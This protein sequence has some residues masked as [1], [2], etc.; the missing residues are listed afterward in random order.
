LQ[1]DVDAGD[2]RVRSAARSITIDAEFPSHALPAHHRRAG[3]QNRHHEFVPLSIRQLVK[4]RWN[5]I[6]RKLPPAPLRIP[7]CV[8]PDVVF[9]QNNSAA[10]PAMV[11][12]VTFIGHATSLLQVPAGDKGLTLLTDPVFS[13]RASPFSFMGPRRAQPPGMQLKQLPH[14]DVVLISHNHYDHLDAASVKALAAQPGGSP[15]FLVPLGLAKWFRARGMVHVVELDWWQTHRIERSVAPGSDEGHAA[16]IDLML[17]P[18][19][20][21][22]GRALHDRLRT[23]WGGFAILASEFHAIYSGDTGY[24]QDFADIAAHLADR[25]RP[26][27]GGGFDLALLPVG[28]YQPRALMRTQHVDPEEA[29]K[30]HRDLGAKRSIGVHWGTFELTD[31]SIDEPPRELARAVA[32][33]GL[34]P[35]EFTVMA[36]GQTL[37]LPRRIAC[38]AAVIPHPTHQHP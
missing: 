22:S 23:L 37:R 4:W 33:A 9:L 35:D 27:N 7:E 1:Q 34:G 3:F 29:V 30:I 28:A 13:D 24:S 10:G 2:P 36:I 16:S 17:T 25:Q 8:M 19:Q 38:A 32:A 18:A 15:L 21:W 14:V 31:E 5:A 6:R 26:E 20:H 11:P 12:T